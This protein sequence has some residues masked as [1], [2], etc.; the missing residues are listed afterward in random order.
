MARNA[1]ARWLLLIHHIPPTPAYLRMKVGRRLGRIGAVALKNSVYILPRSD[2]AVED[3]QWIRRETVDGGGNATVV[4]AHFVDG[5]S[6][7]EVEDL[8]RSARDEDYAALEME[9]RAL[10]KR[11]R[12]RLSDGLRR[13]LLGDLERLERRFEEIAA[14]DFFSASGRETVSGLVRALRERVSSAVKVSD[15]PQAPEE[16]YHART[17]VT[18][19]G[20]H[21][22]RIASAWLIRRFIDPEARFRF[23]PAKGYKPEPGELRFDMFE[24]EFSH[25][26]DACTFEVLCARMRLAEPGLRAVAEVVHDI[27]L[28][29]E[30]HRRP[31]T[32][33]VAAVVAGICLAHCSDEERLDQGCRLFESLFLFYARRKETRT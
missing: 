30:K 33:G 5:L 18:R 9:V 7:T 31:E 19:G 2:G 27:D 26:G 24:A 21:V 12:G 20:I 22:D 3:L 6:D 32:A 10:G 17:W 15:G 25:E 4:E 16:G 8:F 28:K 11:P 23:V 14:I 29:D 1:P 13:E